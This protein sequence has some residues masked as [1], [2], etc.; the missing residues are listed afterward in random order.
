MTQIRELTAITLIN[1]KGT[2]S[3]SLE[4]SEGG[5]RTADMFWRRIT[6]ISHDL[7]TLDQGPA[8]MSILLKEEW[9]TV[10]NSTASADISAVCL[11]LHI[12]EK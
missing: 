3:S 7:K 2:H 11:E 5:Y 6:F 10:F 1:Y 8:L 12:S 4:M 9:A